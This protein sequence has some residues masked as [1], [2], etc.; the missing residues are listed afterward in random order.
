[1]AK[2]VKIGVGIL[3]DMGIECSGLAWFCKWKPGV[4]KLYC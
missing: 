3:K 2:I 4:I 1:V